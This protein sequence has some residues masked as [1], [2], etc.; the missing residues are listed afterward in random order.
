MTKTI[1]ATLS[2]MKKRRRLSDSYFSC[3]YTAI[4]VVK[5]RKRSQNWNGAPRNPMLHGPRPSSCP[6]CKTNGTAAI[7]LHEK[8][9]RRTT[10]TI[11]PRKTDGTAT[12]TDGKTIMRQLCQRMILLP[13]SALSKMP[14]TDTKDCCPNCRSFRQVSFTAM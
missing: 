8:H 2:S 12:N 11:N 4:P 9:T 5:S 10:L 3:I 14:G 1:M 13:Y 7:F 6:F